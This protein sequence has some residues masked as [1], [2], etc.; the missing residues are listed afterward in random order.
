MLIAS[1]VIDLTIKVINADPT[2]TVKIAG[3]ISVMT[4]VIFEISLQDAID[5]ISVTIA[6]LAWVGLMLALF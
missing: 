2:I 3:I 4:S 5:R 1:S 6:T